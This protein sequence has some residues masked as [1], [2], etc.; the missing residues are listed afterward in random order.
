M[1]RRRLRSGGEDEISSN[2]ETVWNRFP[3][4]VGRNFLIPID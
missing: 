4:E 1:G 2:V 3:G